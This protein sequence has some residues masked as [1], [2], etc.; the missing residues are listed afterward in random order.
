MN[1]IIALSMLT[2][3]GIGSYV[4]ASYTPE[5]RKQLEMERQARQ[6]T[7]LKGELA[8][9]ISS[10]NIKWLMDNKSSLISS[11]V[12]TEAEWQQIIETLT[13]ETQRAETPVTRATPP[14]EAAMAVQAKY[15]AHLTSAVRPSLPR[16]Q[17]RLVDKEQTT[18]H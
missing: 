9:A 2:I 3:V 13:R 15:K 6:K 8:K 5:M 11:E 1:K 12:L 10:K 17:Y 4:R 14:S 7:Y 18:S 16:R